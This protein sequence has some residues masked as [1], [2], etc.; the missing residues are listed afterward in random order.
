MALNDYWQRLT[1]LDRLIIAALLALCVLAF[2]VLGLRSPGQSVQVRQKQ[3]TVFTAPLSQ[4]RSV[5]LQGPLG[6]TR[7]EIMN[8]KAR[9]VSSPCPYKVCIGMGEIHREGEIVACVPNRLLVQVTGQQRA[10]K[11]KTYD[12]LSR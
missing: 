9:I 10:E 8:G 3:G 4:D 5:E 11:E 6:V 2:V 7:L 1:R 12:L